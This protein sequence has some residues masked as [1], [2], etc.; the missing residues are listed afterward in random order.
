[1]RIGIDIDGVLTNYNQYV[2]KKGKEYCKKYGIN[3]STN[4]NTLSTKKMFGWSYYHEAK[5]WITH[6][7]DYA[8]NNPVMEDASNVIKKLKEE[9]NEIYIITSRWLASS[10]RENSPFNNLFFKKR[11]RNIVIKWLEENRIT[12]DHII[13]LKNKSKYIKNNQIDIMIEDNPKNIKE[14]SK[15]TKVICYHW[16]YNADINGKNIIRCYNW[17]DI[18]KKIEELTQKF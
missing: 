4:L 17:R 6:I 13:F 2:I 16:G 12:Y 7:L 18:D 8:K 14:F 5:F 15:I 3:K 1:M 9:R 10:K 11:M